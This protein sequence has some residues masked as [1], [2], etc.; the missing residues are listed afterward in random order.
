MKTLVLGLLCCSLVSPCFADRY[1]TETDVIRQRIQPIGKVNVAGQAEEKAITVTQK[2]PET[3]DG[4][5][6]YSKY[7]AACHAMGIAGAP[8]KGDNAWKTRLTKYNGVDGLLQSAIRGINAM[9]ARG[10]CSECDDTQLKAAI[11]FMLP[12]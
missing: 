10:T 3:L 2:Q 1:Q 11:E 6:I 7:C 9:P 4:K 5:T 8:K 12:S